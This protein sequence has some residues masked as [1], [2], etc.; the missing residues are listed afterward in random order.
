MATTPTIKLT[1]EEYLEFER[2]SETRHEYLD[3]E[4]FAMVRATPKHTLICGA[5]YASLFN[6]TEDRPCFVYQSD[7]RVKVSETGLYTYPDIAVLCDEPQF[8]DGVQD[9][10]LNPAVIIEVLSPS[11]ELYDRG[12]KFQHY[13]TITTLQEYVL[14][15]QDSVRVERYSRQ[16]DNQ[17]L[18]ADIT[19]L[20]A[21]VELVSIDC[22]L[23]LASIYKKVDM[24][25]KD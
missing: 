24:Q 15:A 14:I 2:A 21:T 22:A 3:G 19:D 6:Q 12:R 18:L 23:R 5:T 20:Q 1:V 16:A 25:A 17:W 13:R 8:E 9:T 7:M 11:T 4:V 10:L